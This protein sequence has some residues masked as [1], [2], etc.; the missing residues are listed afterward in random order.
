MKNKQKV[1][2]FILDKNNRLVDLDQ[3]VYSEYHD[4]KHEFEIALKGGEIR[5]VEHMPYEL[6]ICNIK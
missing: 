6:P 3:V 1:T 5:F 2:H 4:R